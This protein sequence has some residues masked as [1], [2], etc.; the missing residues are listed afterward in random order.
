M[1]YLAL[2]WHQHQPVYKDTSHQTQRGSYI[3]PWV[4][5]HAIRDYYFMAALVAEH[6][7]VHFTIN[8]TP[9]LLWQIEDYLQY[10]ATDEASAAET[11]KALSESVTI[12]ER[13][14]AR[15][16][17]ERGL[18][19]LWRSKNNVQQII[20]VFVRFGLVIA[21]SDR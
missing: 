4:R 15:R 14:F 7:K 20:S 11:R 16:Q 10:G 21:D 12:R 18:L 2:L 9:A 8:L 5:L 17:P 19:G 1:F 3:H 6:P 13:F